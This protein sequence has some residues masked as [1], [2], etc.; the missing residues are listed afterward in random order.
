MLLLIPAAKIKGFFV[1][2]MLCVELAIAPT[3]ETVD[4]DIFPNSTYR[5]RQLS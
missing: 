3:I 2:K 4:T 1:K 5:R